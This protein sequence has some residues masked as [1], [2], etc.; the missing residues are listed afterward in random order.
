MGYQVADETEANSSADQGA[1]CVGLDFLPTC[2]SI[3]KQQF[4]H[5]IHIFRVPYLVAVVRSRR[6]IMSSLVRC[7][8]RVYTTTSQSLEAG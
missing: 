1:S 3:R 5:K 8:H 4:D 2:D 7:W 6:L